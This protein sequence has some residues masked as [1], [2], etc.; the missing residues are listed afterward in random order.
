MSSSKCL[1]GNTLLLGVFIR[2]MLM[3]T[4]IKCPSISYVIL[5][6][7][8]TL[9]VNDTNVFYVNDNLGLEKAFEKKSLWF[10]SSCPYLILKM[11][12]VPTVKM[13]LYHLYHT[14]NM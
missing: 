13:H 10:I 8:L 11:R 9:F 1:L 5:N 4:F 7:K 2:C 3:M 6:A 14:S 12:N